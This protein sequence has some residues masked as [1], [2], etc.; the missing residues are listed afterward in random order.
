MA[1]DPVRRVAWFHVV[2]ESSDE[3]V[4]NRWL[5]TVN[6]A[7]DVFARQAADICEGKVKVIEVEAPGQ[8]IPVNALRHRE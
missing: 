4:V 3:E 6:Q 1:T 8:S 7:V 2:I 5:A